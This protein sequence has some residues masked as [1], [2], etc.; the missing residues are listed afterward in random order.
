MTITF[1]RPADFYDWDPGESAALRQLDHCY[2]C[3]WYH[4]APSKFGTSGVTP[5]EMVHKWEQLHALLGPTVYRGEL[6]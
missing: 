5:Q 4:A 2:V 6:Q 3:G 1:D